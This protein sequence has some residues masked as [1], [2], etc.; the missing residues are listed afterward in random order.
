M[1]RVENARV[2]EHEA[3]NDEGPIY[4]FGI[5]GGKVLC[6]RGAWMLDLDYG[7]AAD[8]PRLEADDP[9]FPASSFTVH[10]L[11]DIGDVFRIDSLG[12]PLAP[13]A[14]MPFK[15]TLPASMTRVLEDR[16]ADSI[17]LEGDFEELLDLA[18]RER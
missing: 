5:G 12:A 9:V 11:R 2:I 18:R 15:A 6:L 10:R 4:Y 7:L 14:T 16:A 17:V 1:I 13:E 3:H 8:D